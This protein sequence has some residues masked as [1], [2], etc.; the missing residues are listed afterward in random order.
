MEN[1]FFSLEVN[2]NNRFI[3]IFQIVFGIIC[4][5]LAV[6]WLV[7]NLDSLKSNGTLWLSV[8]FLL[9]F[10]WYQ[11]NSGLGKGDKFIEIGETT[12]KYKKNSLLPARE[13]NA[14]D[15]KKAEIFPLSLV[16]FLK[17]GKK[18]IMRFGTTY[19]DAIQPIKE[20]IEEF[21]R[22]NNL[23]LEFRKEEL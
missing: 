16:L 3:R 9:G 15:I 23:E 10:S 7:L 11:I 12:L 21:C 22:L 8:I 1:N 13:F 18:R 6:V 4:S 14:A 19:T 5:V 20:R 2:R 17:S